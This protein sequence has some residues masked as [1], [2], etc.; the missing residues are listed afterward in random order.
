MCSRSNNG[1]NLFLLITIDNNCHLNVNLDHFG[2]PI[3][4]R[5]LYPIL[6][7]NPSSW[8]H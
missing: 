7:T 3:F 8:H 1:I 5:V 4:D 6:R 2:S